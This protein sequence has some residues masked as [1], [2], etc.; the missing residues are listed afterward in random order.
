MSLECQ[1]LIPFDDDEGI[2][3]IPGPEPDP[4]GSGAVADK[5]TT[6]EKPEDSSEREWPNTLQQCGEMTPA[7]K[8]RLI[9]RDPA[10]HSNSSRPKF[11]QEHSS[12]DSTVCADAGVEVT[13]DI[14]LFRLRHSRQD[15]V[16]A[17]V[18]FVS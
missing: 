1:H 10:T 2:I 15:G 9:Q 8:L 14:Q 4:I 13:E 6:S 12:P 5:A 17:L 7:P 18:E 11:S 3:H 16:Q